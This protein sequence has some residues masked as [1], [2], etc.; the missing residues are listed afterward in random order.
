MMNC[1]KLLMNHWIVF[2]CEII[3]L[4]FLAPEGTQNSNF[5]YNGQNHN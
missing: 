2:V 5:V 4:D 1:T 3:E